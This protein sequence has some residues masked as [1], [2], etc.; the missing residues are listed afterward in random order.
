ML[1]DFSTHVRAG[2][3]TYFFD[4][5]QSQDGTRY[6]VISESRKGDAGYEHHRVMVFDEYLEAFSQALTEMLTQTSKPEKKAYSVDSI[7]KECPKAYAKWNADDDE[8]LWSPHQLG[9]S[10]NELASVFQRRP[11]AIESRLRMLALVKASKPMES[12]LALKSGDAKLVSMK[13]D[14]V[15][16]DLECPADRAWS[17]TRFSSRP[18]ISAWPS[19]QA[20]AG[21]GIA[22]EVVLPFGGKLGPV[23]GALHPRQGKA[24]LSLN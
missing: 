23:N 7:R 8:R 5:K 24:C 3:R 10:A 2:S 19:A 16:P 18:Y 12:A 4:M 17:A 13:P 21:R 11:G 9:R 1:A 22:R 14:I 6:L 15:S 20:M